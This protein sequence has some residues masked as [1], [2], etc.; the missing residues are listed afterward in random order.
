M[1]APFKWGSR[2]P[3]GSGGTPTDQA[4]GKV[5]PIAPDDEELQPQL[6]LHLNQHQHQHHHLHHRLHARVFGS[7][8]R[9]GSPRPAADES[10]RCGE[11]PWPTANP[12]GTETQPEER[13]ETSWASAQAG[14]P[15]N[16]PACCPR[17]T[18]AELQ[19]AVVKTDG[20]QGAIGE[21]T[22]AR[23]PPARDQAAL[24]SRRTDLPRLQPGSPTGPPRDRVS[25]QPS[26]TPTEPT[27]DSAGLDAAAAAPTP[28]GKL[29]GGC[30]GCQ[31]GRAYNPNS[32]NS[33][34]C[35]QTS[36]DTHADHANWNWRY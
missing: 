27:T 29:G 4:G 3:A 21:G 33:T 31:Y 12:A 34:C 16:C 10:R 23:G 26:V 15:R 22:S 25:G 6:R 32:T 28:A 11:E 9:G 13:T 36:P 7:G 35:D 14:K 5:L 2:V 17:T 24:W 19:W 20:A 30:C 1:G 8:A 18:A